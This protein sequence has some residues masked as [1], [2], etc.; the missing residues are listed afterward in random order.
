LNAAALVGRTE[1]L[2]RLKGKTKA[3]LAELPSMQVETALIYGQSIEFSTHSDRAFDGRQIIWVRSDQ[4]WFFGWF[5]RVGFEGFWVEAD[6]AISEATDD[7]ILDFC[8]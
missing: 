4:P 2:A 5:T 1:R 6:G 7:D 8:G 3:E